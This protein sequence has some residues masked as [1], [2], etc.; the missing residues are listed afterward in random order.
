MKP[1]QKTTTNM[2]HRC[3]FSFFLALQKTMTSLPTHHH[4]LQF[5]EKKNI[6]T[7]KKTTSLSARH[8]PLQPK[9]KHL[10]AGFSWVVGDNN[11]PQDLPSSLSFF[12]SLVK[13]GDEPRDS[14]LFVIFFRHL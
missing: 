4:L 3:L 12:L 8:R 13:D 10:D 6:K 9:K 5:K 14:S 11:E 7:Q 2:P 1:R